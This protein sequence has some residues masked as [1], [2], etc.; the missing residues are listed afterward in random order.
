M[1]EPIKIR[2]LAEQMIRLSGKR[3]GADIPIEYI[4]LRPGEKLYEELFYSTESLNPTDHPQIRMAQ[5]QEAPDPGFAQALN[6]LV[7]ALDGEETQLRDRLAECL[8]SI[9]QTEDAHV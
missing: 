9:S 1:G 2:Y 3:P 5:A 8:S 4:G 6:R 7:A